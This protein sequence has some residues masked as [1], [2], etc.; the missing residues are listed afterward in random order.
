MTSRSKEE[1]RSLASKAS[2]LSDRQNTVRA[3]DLANKPAVAPKRPRDS[4]STNEDICSPETAVT[5]PRCVRHMIREERRRRRR[6]N[7]E[8]IGKDA[9]QTLEQL[10]SALAD[11]QQAFANHKPV[12]SPTNFSTASSQVSPSAAASAAGEFH[13]QSLNLCSSTQPRPSAAEVSPHTT[14]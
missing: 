2:I 9:D 14:C 6:S 10:S 8:S 5:E 13:S 12:C 4:L 3:P 1:L 7:I 11:V